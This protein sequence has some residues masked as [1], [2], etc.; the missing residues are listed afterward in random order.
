MS[1]GNVTERAVIVVVGV[2]LGA[3]MLPGAALAHIE[4]PS[5]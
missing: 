5:Y 1:E 2:V 4:R 3:I